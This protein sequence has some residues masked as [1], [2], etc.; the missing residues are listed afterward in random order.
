MSSGHVGVC[1]Y[2]VYEKMFSLV[3]LLA[4]SVLPV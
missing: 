2:C 3:G 1:D 4:R